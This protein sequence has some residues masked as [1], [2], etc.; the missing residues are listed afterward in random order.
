MEDFRLENIDPEEIGYLLVEVQ[1]S[2]NIKF[3]DG[4]LNGIENFGELC[5]H[6]NNKIDLGNAD[7][8]TSQQA[9]YKLRHAFSTTL[10]IDNQEITRYRKLEDLFPKP[11]RRSKVK[12]LEQHLGMNLK[13]LT[14]PAWVILTLL[15]L[16]LLSLL[17]FFYSWK[18]AL[19][20]IS[21]SIVGFWIADLTANEL[22]PENIEQLVKQMTRENYLKSRRNPETFNRK[23]VELVLTDWFSDKF[24]LERTELTGASKF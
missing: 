14:S 19:S 18:L 3:K 24:A 15:A 16:S 2:F 12:I 4:E 1:K 21:L 10:K 11:T 5:D 20:G 17:C 9:F 7:D 23:E 6:I 13:T 8:C 22:N